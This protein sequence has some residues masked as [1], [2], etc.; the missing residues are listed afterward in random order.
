ML[1]IPAIDRIVDIAIYADDAEFFRFYPIVDAPRFRTDENGDP[2]FLMLS[3]ALSDEERAAHPD[4]P[5]GGG[6]LSFDT[7]FE[8]TADELNAIRAALAPRVAAEWSRLKAGSTQDQARSGVAGTNAPPEVALAT[9]TW[10]GGR[11]TMDAPRS[12]RLIEA[13][14]AE[15]VPS[16]LAGNIASFSMDLTPAGADFMQQTLLSEEGETADETPIQIAYDLDFWARLPPARIHLEVNAER[17][18][19]YIEER[20]HG[21]SAAACTGYDYEN[22]DV[23]TESLTLSGAVTVQIDTG[24][25]SLPE[26]VISELRAYAFDLAK[27][28]IQHS[29]F[30]AD[31]E[32]GAEPAQPAP[33]R[34][35]GSPSAPYYRRLRGRTKLVRKEIDQQSMSI[36]LDLE[37]SSVVPWSIH[38]RGTMQTLLP[39]NF[40]ARRKHVRQLRLNDPFFATLEITTRVFTDF[41]LVDHVE[42]E[43]AYETKDE[44]GRPHVTGAVL[45]FHDSTPQIWKT[46]V[47]GGTREY[48]WRQRVVLKSG[49]VGP[50]SEWTQTHRLQLTISIEAPGVIDIEVMS[51]A[52]DFENLVRG[53]QVVLAYEDPA[54]G[55][56]REEATVLLS[57]GKL[58]DRYRR[59]ID[60]TWTHPVLAKVRFD[61]AS[62]DVIDSG[63]WTEINGRQLVVNQPS[64]AVLEVKLLPAG[65]G[66]RDIVAVMVDLSY[67]DAANNVDITDT[68]TLKALDGFATWSVYLRDRTQRAY[69]Y[70]WTASFA[71]GDLVKRDWTDVDGDPVLPIRIERS[72]ISVT[73]VADSLDFTDCPLTEITLR[74][75]VPG[76][77][78]ETLIFR[79]KVA[80]TWH[81]DVPDGAP[82][83]FAYQVTHF[84]AGRDPVVLT[85][86]RETDPIIVLPAYRAVSAGE[87]RVQIMAQLVDFAVTPIVA[88]D[89]N[90]QDAPNGVDL[91]NSVSLDA[92][93]RTANW[94]VPTRD[95]RVTAF[96]SRVTHFLSDGTQKA[97]EWQSSTIP[98]VVVPAYRPSA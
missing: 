63:E 53:V 6:Y 34:T 72:G 97:G 11:V 81:L 13:R 12:E 84:P 65:N 2:V 26:E 20:F 96:R 23:D 59:Q 82:V 51:G 67:K 46:A 25:G 70:R 27:Q 75:D 86:R 38:P 32:D 92:G 3:Y 49:K 29:F 5:T 50:Y 8:A 58:V 54:S 95:A 77:A 79:D 74:H 31:G 44:R 17:M 55:V 40:E 24:S 89:L 7:T 15:S 19:K 30:S 90:Y 21:R 62:G 71:N 45:G 22:A 68:F 69:R 18:H 66:W 47:V 80:Q 35:V 43:L 93:Q 42:V 76:G 85:E 14:V 57:P 1:L 41:S 16:L 98:R 33:K 78:T 9:P 48:K 87:L 28:L 60:A 64:E 37:Q 91:S 61:L 73:V 94:V 52:I 10:I 36:K 4:L 39:G 56:P 88:V 83:A